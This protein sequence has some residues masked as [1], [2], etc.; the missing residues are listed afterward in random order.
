MIRPWFKYLQ[1][2]IYFFVCH[3]TIDNPEKLLNDYNMQMR[4]NFGII[5]QFIP[6]SIM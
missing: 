4:V 1:H 2:T 6:L 5:I 3:S